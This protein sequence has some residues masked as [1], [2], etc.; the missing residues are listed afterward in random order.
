MFFSPFWSF[1]PL[2]SDSGNPLSWKSLLYLSNLI[3]NL[4]PN[5][6]PGSFGRRST[7]EPVFL[8][9]RRRQGLQWHRG[10]GRLGQSKV[11]RDNKRDQANFRSHQLF[12]CHMDLTIFH[13]LIGKPIILLDWSFAG[14]YPIIFEEQALI[15]QFNLRGRRF[16][17][18]LFNQLFGD[19]PSKNM[20]PLTLAARINYVGWWSISECMKMWRGI[21]S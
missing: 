21:A 12:F 17:K 19:K 15:N 18:G 7:H 20:R 14:I 16:A 11:D 3:V 4:P 5:T 1:N 6:P 2:E 8:R 13:V 10:S 9:L